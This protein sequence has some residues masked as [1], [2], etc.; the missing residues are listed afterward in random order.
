MDINSLA[1]MVKVF[2]ARNKVG[3]RR[4]LSSSPSSSTQM[5]PQELSST[6]SEM[7][8][9]CV[10]DGDATST[11]SQWSSLSIQT[12]ASALRC[13]DDSSNSR[14]YHNQAEYS[15][16]AA[17]Q[18]QE[19]TNTDPVLSMVVYEPCPSLPD[20]VQSWCK[21]TAVVVLGD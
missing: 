7:D 14:D 17:T 1:T 12:D 3:R 21:F 10:G 13:V 16:R 4:P 11:T 2:R 15:Y 20:A 6:V 18:R 5:F 19:G 8:S 9:F